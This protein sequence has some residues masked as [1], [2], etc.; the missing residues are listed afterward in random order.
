MRQILTIR[1]IKGKKKKKRNLCTGKKKVYVHTGDKNT[2][3]LKKIE[4]SWNYAR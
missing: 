1:F 3:Q 2:N 4:T